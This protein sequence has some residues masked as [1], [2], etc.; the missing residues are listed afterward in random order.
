MPF[1]GGN[2]RLRY[3][4]LH[5]LVF[6]LHLSVGPNAFP[7]QPPVPECGSSNRGPTAPKSDATDRTCDPKGERHYKPRHR[8][9]G[10][11]ILDSESQACFV[12]DQEYQLLDNLVD[13]VLSKVK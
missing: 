8:G 13:A 2:V 3:I 7:Q 10:F 9:I 12:P 5:L 1:L 11:E 6:T 4:G